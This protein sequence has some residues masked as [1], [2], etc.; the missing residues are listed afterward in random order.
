MFQGLINVVVGSA[1]SCVDISERELTRVFRKE[2]S[3]QDTLRRWRQ[4]FAGELSYD[5]GSMDKA[6]RRRLLI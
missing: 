5:A 3:K 1:H 4:V 2:V 6:G